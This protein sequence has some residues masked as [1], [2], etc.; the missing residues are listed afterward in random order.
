[1]IFLI[2]FKTLERDKLIKKTLEEFFNN[3]L[4]QNLNIYD[5]GEISYENIIELMNLVVDNL[6]HLNRE[7]NNRRDTVNENIRSRI[8]EYENEQAEDI[9]NEL[10]NEIQ[11]FAQ[12]VKKEEEEKEK[13][14][15]KVGVELKKQD[16]IDQLNKFLLENQPAIEGVQ[17]K[18]S[19]DRERIL[20]D[21]EN[22]H[23]KIEDDIDQQDTQNN[24]VVDE[25]LRAISYITS[26][27]TPKAPEFSSENI[28]A[29]AVKNE[30]VDGINSNS[31][32]ISDSDDVIIIDDDDDDE[33]IIIDDDDNDGTQGGI[34][35]ISPVD[36]EELIDIDHKDGEKIKIEVKKESELDDDGDIDFS[37]KRE[38]TEEGFI[39]DIPNRDNLGE[40][41]F[42]DLTQ[43]DSDDDDEVKLKDDPEM[44]T[45][46]QRLVPASQAL[47]IL[48]EQ[49]QNETKLEKVND[50]GNTL[51]A[52]KYKPK[53][54]QKNDL[55]VIEFK[56]KKTKKISR[57]YL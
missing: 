9:E 49:E 20:L 27:T 36:D 48:R 53:R 11:L 16:Y 43:D 42:I 1:M 7:I 56:P 50:Q 5:V 14:N 18:K 51:A 33:V 25:K 28:T 54:K 29:P 4:E 37:I 55:E 32:L 26:E 15:F 2:Y 34:I 41:I 22:P 31:N 38:E 39:R 47:N 57:R 8:N 19:E 23:I 21:I 10:N 12:S 35:H 40:Q 45:D 46:F 3:L 17:Q 44:N 24:Q 52:V 13:E 30:N 6:N